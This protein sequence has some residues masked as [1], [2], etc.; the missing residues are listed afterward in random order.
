MEKVKLTDCFRRK[1]II[2]CFQREYSWGEEEIEELIKNIKGINKEYCLGI[3]TVKK[4]DKQYELIDGQQR[5]TTLYM[6]AICSGYLKQN[7][8]VNLINEYDYLVNNKKNKLYKL[9]DKNPDVFHNIRNGWKTVNKYI[10]DEDKDFIKEAITKYLYYYE[11]SLDDNI[12]LNHYFEVMNSRGVQLS[13]SDIIK[14]YIMNKL[15]NDDDKARLNYLWYKY[16]NMDAIT[17]NITSFKEIKKKTKNEYKSINEIL[18]STSS[19]KSDK[20]LPKVIVND[21]SSILNF[22]YF[23]LYVIRLYKNGDNLNFDVSGEFNLKSLVTEYEDELSNKDSNSIVD[24]LDYLIKMKNIYDKYIVKYDSVNESWKIGIK[25]NRLILIQSCLRVSFTNRRLMH[26]IYIT[27]LYFY[28]SNDIDDYIKMIDNYIK[29]NYIRKFISD[30]ESKDYRTGFDTPIIVLNYL[31]YLIKIH[32]KEIA[33][34]FPELIGLKFEDY[35][36][37]FR[38][39]IEHFM[40]RH[41]ENGNFNDEWVDDF[42]NLAL[43]S[44]GTNTRMQNASPD[45][46]ASH[47]NKDLSGY[48]LKLQ[49]MTKITLDKNR[50]WNEHESKYV[51]KK[52]IEILEKYL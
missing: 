9:F 15:D 23:L 26:W 30:N 34:T 25:N 13:R 11:I 7:D 37:K 35:K 43:L 42:G 27:L 44:Y 38:N 41:N 18:N 36:F 49:I 29:N 2:P 8:D 6:I 1:Y 48:S 12:D 20:K 33:N 40:P 50:N 52:S 17:D 51:N 10:K 39:S 21:D 24:F 19:N 28:N 32:H 45:V 22:E 14:S 31:D 5:L 16:E 47:F 4:N 46:K 3:I